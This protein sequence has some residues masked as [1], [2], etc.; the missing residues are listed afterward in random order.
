MVP[1]F[2]I[3]AGTVDINERKPALVE[4]VDRCMKVKKKIENEPLLT[5]EEKKSFYETIDTQIGKIKA[6]YRK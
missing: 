2:I 3:G 6:S 5:K 1:N 4:L